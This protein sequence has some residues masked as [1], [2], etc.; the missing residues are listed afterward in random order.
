MVSDHATLS[1]GKTL[2][3]IGIQQGK[4]SLD[5]STEE[6]GRFSVGIVRTVPNVEI[7]LVKTEIMIFDFAMLPIS[8]KIRLLEFVGPEIMNLNFV[9]GLA[10]LEC[11]IASGKISLARIFKMWGLSLIHI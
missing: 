8:L 2:G 10:N 11:Q 5:A 6:I 1:V 9:G 7:Y 3:D 4:A